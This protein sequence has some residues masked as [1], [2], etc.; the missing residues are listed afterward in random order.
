MMEIVSAEKDRT[1]K[2]YYFKYP[3]GRRPYYRDDVSK[4]LEAASYA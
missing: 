4:D 3:N 1:K 2:G